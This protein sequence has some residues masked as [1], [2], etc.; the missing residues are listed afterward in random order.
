LHERL[1]VEDSTG[2]LLHTPENDHGVFIRSDS[3]FQLAEI[4][5]TVRVN[6]QVAHDILT[7]VGKSVRLLK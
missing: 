7:P 4:R 5:D 3:S 1:R 2:R 6:T